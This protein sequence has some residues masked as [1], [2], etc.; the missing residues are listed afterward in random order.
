MTRY[1][2]DIYSEFRNSLE[3]VS[4][5]NLS[6]FDIADL[7]GDITLSFIVIGAFFFV[8][9]ILGCIGACCTVRP[10][11]IMVSIILSSFGLVILI[12]NWSLTVIS[13]YRTKDIQHNNYNN[14]VIWEHIVLLLF[15]ITRLLRVKHHKYRYTLCT[16]QIYVRLSV[17]HLEAKYL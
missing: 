10:M 9:G 7:I 14:A 3:N 12:Y 15:T 8:I 1:L 16:G 13:L 5:A 17:K 4:D 6:N 2:A 11:L